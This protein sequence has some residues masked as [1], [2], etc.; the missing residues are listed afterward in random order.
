V[1][2]VPVCE[3]APAD[4]DWETTVPIGSS[5]GTYWTTAAS[6]LPAR[7]CTAA[8]RSVP[9]SD[10]TA[11]G[12]GAGVDGSA[13]AAVVVGVAVFTPEAPG[14]SEG[15]R[16]SFSTAPG[17]IRIAYELAQRTGWTVRRRIVPLDS[18]ARDTVAQAVIDPGLALGAHEV[19][20]LF[21]NVRRGGALIVTVDGA[22]E[23]TDSLGV[24]LGPPGRILEGYNDPGCPDHFSFRSRA[25]LT[26]P[27]EIR[28]LVWK[29]K[30]DGLTTVVHGQLR[31]R[32]DLPV[33][34]G[35]PL[36]K[37]RVVVVSQ[38]AIFSNDAIRVCEWAADLAVARILEY[39]KP[40]S[41]GRV[42]V[43]DEY[44]H[45]FGEHSSAVTAIWR[46]MSTTR[47]GHFLAQLLLAGLIVLLAFGPRPLP[48]VDPVRVPRRS[49]LEHADALAH[50]YADVDAT[51]TATARLV[52]G[53]RRRAGRTVAAPS[54]ASDEIFL[55]AVAAQDASLASRVAVVLTALRDPIPA[56]DLI[57]VGDAIRTIE[58]QLLKPPQRTK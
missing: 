42:L 37:G 11:T 4:G 48:P 13:L 15:G 7:F 12:V 23:I 33:A 6:S 10:G 17:G 51:R 53:L 18:F 50:A 46:Y 49:P 54:G 26:I 58:Q 9:V 3:L 28:G 32:A 27:P 38:S 20:R 35:F 41:G 24:D 39:A 56:S 14:K 43:F 19:H 5:L 8:F 16:S 25:L 30:P 1:M 36:G 47:S 2:R 29:K 21:E 55:N 40:A 31:D 45:G 52:S 22:D 44:H 34:E 57:Q